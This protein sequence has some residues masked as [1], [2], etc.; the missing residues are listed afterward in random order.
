MLSVLAVLACHAAPDAGPEPVATPWHYEEDPS[1]VVPL[2][3]T[4]LAG[5]PDAIMATLTGVDPHD[6]Y[7][8]WTE[9]GDAFDAECPVRGDHN[10]Q[11]LF[12]G[13]CTAA[14]G[15]AFY[16][17]QLVN[18]IF[19]FWV[20]FPGIDGFQH[21]YSW[22]TGNSRAEL[23]D[24]R[25]VTFGGDALWS[26]RQDGDG[27]EARTLYL[28]GNF[29]WERLTEAPAWMDARLEV[30]L[31]LEAADL[32]DGTRAVAWNGGVTG[33]SG[34]VTAFRMEDLALRDARVDD[35]VAPACT[36]EPTGAL[37][38]LGRDGR[39]YAVVF[40][41]ICDGCTRVTGAGVEQTVCADWSPVLGW[42]DSPWER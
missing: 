34:V 25:V 33:L 42:G 28:Y 38:F 40:D 14:S 17:Y 11:P 2:S 15:A 10:G 36:L 3:G 29:A 12:E 4:E 23:A 24:G 35:V 1:A 41:E 6:V 32:P 13:D 37:S 31:H 21:E 30:E 9:I 8:A 16:G 5:A 26:S 27:Y 22:M 20:E 19:G 18:R 7:D 39:W